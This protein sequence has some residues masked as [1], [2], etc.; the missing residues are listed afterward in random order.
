VLIFVGLK[1]AVLNHLWGGHFPITVSLAVIMGVIAVSVT[2]SLLFPKA[3][4]EP[5]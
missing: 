1:M 3:Q 5:R 4:E 2:L